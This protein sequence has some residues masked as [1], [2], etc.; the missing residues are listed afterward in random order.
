MSLAEPPS[1]AARAF[2]G[3][4]DNASADQSGER[5]TPAWLRDGATQLVSRFDPLSDDD[6]DVRE[7]FLVRLAVRGTA[8]Q[9]RYFRDE[10][11]VGLAPINDDFVF[12]HRRAAQ[13]DPRLLRP[14]HNEL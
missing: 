9:L 7:S 5:Q 3:R 10:R 2:P 12:S 13:W 14:S 1:S 8:R 11:L 6:F 4:V